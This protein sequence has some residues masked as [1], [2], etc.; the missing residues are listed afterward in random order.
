MNFK[1]SFF[2]DPNNF[3]VIVGVMILFS[4]LIVVVARWR[5]WI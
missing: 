5:H 4:V 2:D 1:P 3:F